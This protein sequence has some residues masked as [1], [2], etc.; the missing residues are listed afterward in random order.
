MAVWN[1]NSPYHHPISSIQHSLPMPII[2]LVVWLLLCTLFAHP[3]WMEAGLRS[4]HMAA[5]LAQ[6]AAHHSAV[7]DRWGVTALK[8]TLLREFAARHVHHQPPPPP[9]RLGRWLYSSATGEH[10]ALAALM[11]QPV[12]SEGEGGPT[13]PQQLVL[14]AAA[15]ERDVAHV[16][17]TTSLHL[18]EQQRRHKSPIHF[19]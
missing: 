15:I 9:E 17:R 1:S 8:G 19:H 18:G 16:M 11:R 7:T 2:S 3:S 5:H 6:E 4:P 10:G 13:S 12:R 14:D